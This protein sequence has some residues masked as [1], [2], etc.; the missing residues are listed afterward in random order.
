M[1]SSTKQVLAEQAEALSKMGADPEFVALVQSVYDDMD[2]LSTEQKT[3]LVRL[4]LQGTSAM[5]QQISES[6]PDNPILHAYATLAHGLIALGGYTIEAIRDEAEYTATGDSKVQDVLD[7]FET[8]MQKKGTQGMPSGL[9]ERLNPIKD[10]MDERIKGGMPVAE[11]VAKAVEE[12][13]AVRA[14]FEGAAPAVP[15]AKSEE[16]SPGYGMYL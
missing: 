5:F 13:N 1:S 9:E 11:A 15:Q 2:A 16:A 3:L 8:V 4:V 12:T 7:K 6:F 14:E 10:R